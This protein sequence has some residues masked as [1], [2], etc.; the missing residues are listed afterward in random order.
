MK[1][2]VKSSYDE[3][4]DDSKRKERFEREYK[5]LLLSELILA[6]IKKDNASARALAKAAGVSLTCHFPVQQRQ[7]K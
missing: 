2:I 6:I 4:M 5:E 1:K 3:L 7:K